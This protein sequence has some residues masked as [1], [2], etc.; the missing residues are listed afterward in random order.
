MGQELSPIV[1]KISE[2]AVVLNYLILPAIVVTIWYCIRQIRN[3]KFFIT[4]EEI[5]DPYLNWFHRATAKFLDL[6]SSETVKNTGKKA[7][8]TGRRYI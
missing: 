7:T 4:E 8:G 3:G 1:Q 2:I 5:A 6:I